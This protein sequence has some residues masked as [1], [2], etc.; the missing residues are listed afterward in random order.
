LIWLLMRRPS[1]RKA[2]AACLV[3][4]IGGMVLRGA[5]WL[6]D[7]APLQGHD[8]F[9]RRF[10]E[11]LYYPTWTRLDGLLAGLVLALVKTFRPGAWTRLM[12][13]SNALMIAGLAAVAV[14]IVLFQDQRALL[15][16][17]IG[18]PVLAAGMGLLVA[19]GAS[20]RSL[21]GRWRIPGAGAI[22]A[23]AFSLYLIHKA[24]FHLVLVALGPWARAHPIATVFATGAG[25][26]VAGTLLH[27]LAERPSLWLRDRVLRRVEPAAA[28]VE[29][30]RA[31]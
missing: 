29:A 23:M 6:H 13:R 30:R 21:I 25:A 22:A 7:L 26:L 16:S 31:A 27:L 10:M 19:A 28:K 17:V 9:G 12:A 3:V 2:I 8:G 15:P 11:R 5:I 14:A 18:Y 4:L 1:P 24:A 20:S